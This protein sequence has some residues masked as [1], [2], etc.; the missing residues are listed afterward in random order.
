MVCIFLFLNG[1]D[2][3][4]ETRESEH[5]LLLLV[6]LQRSH[7][8]GLLGVGLE[9][10]VPELGSCIN[11][12]EIDLLQGSLLGVSQQ[13]LTQGQQSLLGSN[14]TSLTLSD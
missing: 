13:R 7:E 9:P 14:T 6:L 1:A 2:T 11:K 12:L 10:S 8:G 4:P 3:I 5:N